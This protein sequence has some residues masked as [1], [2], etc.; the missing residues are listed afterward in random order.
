MFICQKMHCQIKLKM[1]LM[2]Y[3][4]NY[5]KNNSFHRKFY[6][7]FNCLPNYWPGAQNIDNFLSF[8]FSILRPFYVLSFYEGCKV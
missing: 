8:V 7:K 5:I 1:T 2:N 6:K 3:K 4:I